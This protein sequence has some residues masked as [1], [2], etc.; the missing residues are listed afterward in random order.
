[1]NMN[2][3]NAALIVLTVLVIVPIVVNRHAI[4]A[5]LKGMT[6]LDYLDDQIKTLTADLDASRRQARKGSIVYSRFLTLCVCLGAVVVPLQILLCFYDYSPIRV[7][8]TA[9]T[10]MALAFNARELKN[11][12]LK[13][14]RM[15]FKVVH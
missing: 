2:T 15:A 1:M 9:L 13:V 8:T 7:A 12:R 10:A 11:E 6:Y 3:I 4:V 14:K 5:R